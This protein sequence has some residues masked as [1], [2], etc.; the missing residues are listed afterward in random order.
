MGIKFPTPWKTLMIK[1][2]PPRDGKASANRKLRFDRYIK[3]TKRKI[4]SKFRSPQRFWIALLASYNLLLITS[5]L[6]FHFFTV[7]CLRQHF[8]PLGILVTTKY[9]KNHCSPSP[10]ICKGNE[11]STSVRFL[12]NPIHLL[13]IITAMFYYFTPI[14][15]MNRV[16][17]C[18]YI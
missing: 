9:S 18:M 14:V 2:P 3:Q 15:N 8:Y 12:Y 7:P 5:Q 13:C 17:Q 16:E 4:I 1:F 6:I 11:N 10:S